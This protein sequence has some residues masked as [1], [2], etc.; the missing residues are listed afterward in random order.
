LPLLHFSFSEIGSVTS[1]CIRKQFLLLLLS[2][3]TDDG[4][5]SG[6]LEMIKSFGLSRDLRNGRAKLKNYVTFRKKISS[7]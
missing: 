5:L 2:L 6:Y 7:L 4:I 1:L 3:Y